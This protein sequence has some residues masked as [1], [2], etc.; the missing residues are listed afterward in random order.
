MR[1]LSSLATSGNMSYGSPTYGS[2]ASGWYV[3]RKY[4]LKD[5]VVEIAP[6]QTPFLTTLSRFRKMPTN[7]PM[8]R[9]FQHESNW[10]RMREGQISTVASSGATLTVSYSNHGYYPTGANA[11]STL[12]PREI[13]RIVKEDGNLW[14]VQISAV[15]GATVTVTTIN[16]TAA[17]DDSGLTLG[18]TVLGTGHEWGGSRASDVSD[19]LTIQYGKT[20]IFKTAYSVDNTLRHTALYGGNELLRLRAEKAMQHKAEIE[21]AL[22]FGSE[23]STAM[24]IGGKTIQFTDGLFTRVTANGKSKDIRYASS[25]YNDIVDMAEEIFEFGSNNKLFMV[26]NTPLSWFSKIG[27]GTN[28]GFVK[29]SDGTTAIQNTIT[30][31]SGQSSYGMNIRD[32]LTPFGTLKVVHNPMLRGDFANVGF[33]VDLNHVAYR[34]LQGR[35]TTLETNVEDKGTDGVIDQYLTEA[36]LQVENE[37]AH[38]IVNFS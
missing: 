31:S 32:L 13:L 4:D 17:A 8:F 38:M 1:S 24:S 5:S 27:D 7:D 22:L 16:G 34:P 14:F 10:Y 3:R 25:G 26:G 35:D 15:S 20:Q 37:S 2:E 21:R 36:G 11:E 23:E 30:L 6:A 33:V 12:V 28:S 9:F 29:V 18:F 19:D